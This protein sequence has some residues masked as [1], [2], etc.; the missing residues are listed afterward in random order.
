MLMK[1]SLVK[2][3]CVFFVGIACAIP[4]GAQSMT[5]MGIGND[6]ETMG[7]G[8]ASIAAGAS[9]GVVENNIAAAALYDDGYGM[10]D[11]G[12]TLWQP[13]GFNT[14]IV[15]IGGFSK[16]GKRLAV[17]VSGKYLIEQPYQMMEANGL[18]SD[19]FR[20][21]E[22]MFGVGVA[23][24][25]IDGLAVGANFKLGA[26][27]IAPEASAT[28]FAA[29]IHA[30]Y[31]I[32]GVNIGVGVSNLGTKADYGYGGYDIPMLV[33]AGASYSIFGLTVSAEADY[34]A[35]YGFMAS[36]STEYDILGWV[37]VRAGYHYGGAN[38]VLPSFTSV[39]L[40]VN[41]FG[42]RLNAA[43]LIAPADSY[44]RNTMA[45]SVGYAF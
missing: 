43:Y 11:L 34:Q 35:G 26:S 39:G 2:Y 41:I 9:G 24:R 6:V 25:I 31:S 36:A 19:M 21:K 3:I 18:T 42:V 32:K 15:G 33:R 10:A 13:S 22:G 27:G 20:P 4:A 7:L 17:G 38:T 16:I 5:F 29:D 37:D 8:Y 23:C 14:G 12:Y 28:V 44:L 1:I 45:F 30:M 40:G